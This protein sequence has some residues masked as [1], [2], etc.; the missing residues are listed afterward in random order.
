MAL[1]RELEE[2][3]LEERTRFV[4][5]RITLFQCPGCGGPNAYLS[6]RNGFFEKWILRLV[7]MRP[8]RCDFCYKR[9]Y[10]FI[11]VN[12]LPSTRM[13]FAPII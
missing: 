9:S 7:L 5:R 1:L 13:P 10:H 3:E 11:T 8:F 12:A 4:M 2:R 6:R